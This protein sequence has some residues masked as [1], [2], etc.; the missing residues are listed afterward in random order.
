MTIVRINGKVNKVEP[1][2]HWKSNRFFFWWFV[3]LSN[4]S[5]LRIRIQL[6]MICIFD[7]V[8][9]MMKSIELS[10]HSIKLKP[11]QVIDA[12]EILRLYI[13]H[14]NSNGVLF[15]FRLVLCR[16]QIELC[17]M[18]TFFVDCVKHVGIRWERLVG[19]LTSS[20]SINASMS[21]NRSSFTVIETKKTTISK[22]L[23]FL[24]LHLFLLPYSSCGWRIERWC[25]RA[26]HRM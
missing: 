17:K 10:M 16:Y 26:S 6:Y 15:F 25:E 13:Y 11:Y 20:A 5:S 18:Y 14:L 23:Y 8:Q 9:W 1:W 19:Y 22:S 3:R 4:W 24:L 21:F 2:S 12:K 7:H